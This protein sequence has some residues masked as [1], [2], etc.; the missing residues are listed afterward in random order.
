MRVTKA[1]YE[2][3][4]AVRFL[5]LNKASGADNIPAEIFK[6]D[7]VMFSDILHPLLMD[8]WERERFPK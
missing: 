8:I 4:D 6:A 1:R 7:L 5:K 2:I 3:C